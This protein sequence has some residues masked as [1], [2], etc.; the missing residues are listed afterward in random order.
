MMYM[1]NNWTIPAGMRDWLPP[2]AGEKRTLVNYLLQ[3]MSLWGYREIATPVLEQFQVLTKGESRSGPDY[4]YKLIERDGSILV[5]R[6]EMTTP[7]ARVVGTKIKGNPPWRLMY[8]AEVFRYEDI[9]AGRWREFSQAGVELIGQ[10]GPEADSEVLALAI[11]LLQTIGLEQFTVSLGHTGILRGLLESLSWDER[12]LDEVRNLILEKEFAGLY[13]FLERAGLDTVKCEELVGLFTQP[14]TLQD[15]NR[16]LS[17]LPS[18]MQE[19]LAETERIISLVD[20]YGYGSHLQV[21]LST[22]RSQ[23]YYTGMVFEIYTAGIGYP[24]G[25][26]GRYDRLLQHFGRDC[27]ATGFALGVERLLLSL[28]LKKRDEKV[29]LLAGADPGGNHINAVLK[30]AKELRDKGK[31]VIAEL[32]SLSREQ[33]EELAREKGAELIWYREAEKDDG[34]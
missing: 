15:I 9:Q 26:G 7:I 18:G 17:R 11:E 5:L 16:L 28:T 20:S 21:D 1:E 27:P 22:L 2:E 12:A 23:A 33:A 29:M 32:R 24:I 31:A 3:T 25:G 4:L 8:G 10:S 34:V 14:L 6:P 19:A 13:H 30:K